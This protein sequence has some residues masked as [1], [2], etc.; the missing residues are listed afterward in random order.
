MQTSRNLTDWWLSFWVSN[1]AP[2]NSTRN[3]SSFLLLSLPNYFIEI[4]SEVK[5]Y[6]SVYIAFAALNSLFTFFRAFLFAYGGVCAASKVHKLLLKSII[7]SKVV[8]FDISPLGRIL[9]RF[10][11]DTYTVDDSLP[12]IINILLAQFFAVIGKFV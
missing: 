9:N 12:F 2:A 1:A 11:S 3:E 7:R 5:Y 10:S 4:D 6:L 8:F